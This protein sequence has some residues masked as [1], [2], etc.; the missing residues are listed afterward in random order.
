MPLARGT[1]AR[2]RPAAID[3][4]RFPGERVALFECLCEASN[5]GSS[6]MRSSPRSRNDVQPAFG[7]AFHAISSS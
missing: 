2:E 3:A 4:R 7:T 1:V 6:G 5:Q